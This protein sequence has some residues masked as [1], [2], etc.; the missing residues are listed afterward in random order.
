MTSVHFLTEQSNKCSIE[1][2]EMLSNGS[3]THAHFEAVIV[4]QNAIKSSNICFCLSYLC[5]VTTYI[6]K[7]WNI[8]KITI[9]GRGQHWKSNQNIW[10]LCVTGVTSTY[11]VQRPDRWASF[12]HRS[13]S[14]LFSLREIGPTPSELNFVYNDPHGSH[15]LQ[16]WV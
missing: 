16:Y 4:W 12:L 5:F 15:E 3:F 14:L 1:D 9:H 10:V 11:F 7:K 6:S 8:L 13:S 2:K